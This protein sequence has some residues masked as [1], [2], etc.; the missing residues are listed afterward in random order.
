MRVLK[1]FICF[2][3]ISLLVGCKDEVDVNNNEDVVKTQLLE[4][5][6]YGILEF[7]TN[8]RST[9][10]LTIRT[11]SL[12]DGMQNA[13]IIKLASDNL[14]I[15]AKNSNDAY[16][17][18]IKEENKKVFEYTFTDINS[19][20]R[21]Y[22][23]NIDEF[24]YDLIIEDTTNEYFEYDFNSQNIAIE[25]QDNTY[26]M[27]IKYGDF[28]DDSMKD[29]IEELY[30]DLDLDVDILFDL[31][32]LFKYTVDA[33]T[34]LLEI[35]TNLNSTNKY[36]DYDSP[37]EFSVGLSLNRFEI[38]DFTNGRYNLS[39]ATSFDEVFM[40]TKITDNIDQY[41][42]TYLYMYLEAGQ[43]KV[44]GKDESPN[45][46]ITLYDLE[47]KEIVPQFR[48]RALSAR[49]FSSVFV[50]TKSDYYYV[51]IRSTSDAREEMTFKKLDY[52]TIVDEK[53][54][55][56]V[57]DNNV[58]NGFIEGRYDLDYYNYVSDETK[59]VTI[60]NNGDETI[61]IIGSENGY[62]LNLHYIYA[63]EYFTTK[64]EAGDNFFYFTN[65]PYN[66]NESV[67]YSI[68]IRDINENNGLETDY[69]DMDEITDTFSRKLY[70]VSYNHPPKHLKINIKSTGTYKFEYE[71]IEKDMMFRFDLFKKDGT[72]VEYDNENGSVLDPGEYIVRVSNY[73]Y[74]VSTGRIKYTF[75]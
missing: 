49:E 21:N 18:I 46:E 42:T 48:Q 57:E 58:Y 20:K 73:Y 26:L 25:K 28:I 30:D 64:V 3:F 56:I 16:P 66:Q 53:N 24:Q 68:T 12:V 34:M 5:L 59:L 8:L 4:E 52:E 60:Q 33:T 69:D 51:S 14:Y 55:I 71:C 32:I 43:Y 10:F 11:Q 61:Y 63:G 36:K 23:G 50:V 54:P 74:V 70:T 44:N 6:E 40:E 17:T 38:I 22:I 15:E 37:V 13:Q 62:S 45:I 72:S 75:L 31:E 1:L 7:A 19:I 47:K 9:N 27:K 35:S 2:L 39:K 65:H 29:L 67:R 41:K